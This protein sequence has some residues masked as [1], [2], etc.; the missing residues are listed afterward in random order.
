LGNLEDPSIRPS[1]NETGLRVFP[2]AFWLEPAWR[3]TR[4][5]PSIGC[6]PKH[7]SSTSY[8]SSIRRTFWPK[9]RYMKILK[10]CCIC[11]IPGCWN[12]AH[13]KSR[14]RADDCLHQLSD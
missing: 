3:D 10:A 6:G 13:R 7:M 4:G 9:S 8:C 5:L 2:S 11:L 14:L 12:E 1:E